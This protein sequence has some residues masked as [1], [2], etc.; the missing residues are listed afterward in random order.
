M[1]KF[2]DFDGVIV[3]SIDE[4]YVVSKDVYFGYSS[5]LYNEKEYKALFYKYRG[6]VRPAYEYMILHEALETYLQDR[7]YNIVE[8]FKKKLTT[9]S[10]SDKDFYE[11]EFFY[12]RS[13]YQNNDMKNW[14]SMN[15][16]MP[17]G[18]TLIG[19]NNYDVNIV[20]TKNKEATEILLKHYRIK[21][22]KIYANDEIRSFGS[23]GLLIS[24]VM[25]EE[26]AK[27]A[28]FVDDAIEHLETVKDSRVRCLFADW[29]YG[30]NSGYD[31]Y[32]Y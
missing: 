15:P 7:N 12:R 9:R 31:V 21:V 10:S 11:K 1:I 17:F 25:D 19:K 26:S 6:L 13:L 22:N 23:K 24:H 18:E 2:L 20:T 32:K 4:C 3:N 28:I 27:E 29:G 5:F 30:D 8:L 14:L 16:L